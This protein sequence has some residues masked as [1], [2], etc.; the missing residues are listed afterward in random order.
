[1]VA[2]T[3]PSS[4]GVVVLVLDKADAVVPCTL[5]VHPSHTQ[6]SSSVM[7]Q[8]ASVGAI[9]LPRVSTLLMSPRQ[10][11]AGLGLLGRVEAGLLLLTLVGLGLQHVVETG[12]VSFGGEEL[13][14]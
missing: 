9:F 14:R 12:L 2:E 1:M 8:S 11:L 3:L 6:Q 7:H 4:L 13:G 10:S 5:N